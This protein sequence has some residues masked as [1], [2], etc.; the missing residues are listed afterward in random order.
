[1][2]LY[3]DNYLIPKNLKKTTKYTETDIKIVKSLYK[4]K[5][6]IRQIARLSPMSRRL[7]QFTLFPERLKHNK[8][9]FSIRQKTGRYR[10]TTKKQTEMVRNVRNRKKLIINKLIKKHE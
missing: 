5:I 9:L 3:I 10:Y 1:M 7:I 6:P 4:Q 2:P 8:E